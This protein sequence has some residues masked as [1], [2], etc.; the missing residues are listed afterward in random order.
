M[1]ITL[2]YRF[3][4][5]I[6][7]MQHGLRKIEDLKENIDNLGRIKP[8]LLLINLNYVIPDELHL[9]LRI[10]DRLI[11]NLILAAVAADHPAKPL[12]G[13]MF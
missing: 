13:S 12:T 2:T 11:R 4:T 7:A 6:T 5:S 8:P 10:T 1:S 9:L 3:K